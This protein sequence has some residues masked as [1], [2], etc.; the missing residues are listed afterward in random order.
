VSVLLGKGDGTFAAAVDFAAGS[1][2]VA[3]VVGDLNGD[4]KPDAAVLN[5]ASPI[6]ATS[7]SV[8]VL[9]NAGGGAFA[10]PVSYSVA[11]PFALPGNLVMGDVNGD[12]KPDLVTPGMTVLLN[13]G[14]GAFTRLFYDAPGTPT[15]IAA[16]DLDGDGRLDFAVTSGAPPDANLPHNVNVILNAGCAP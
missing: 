16:A 2:P 14:G 12:G 1:A 7:A 8:T 11:G 10:P 15:A 9:I 3:V 13:A 5:I 6:L 4:G